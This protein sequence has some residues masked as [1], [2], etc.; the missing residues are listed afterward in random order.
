METPENELE[1]GD[2]SQL[3]LTHK[4][5]LAESLLTG[6]VALAIIQ[7]M[8]GEPGVRTVVKKGKSIAAN[9]SEAEL[10]GV[11]WK[12]DSC[13]GTDDLPFSVVSEE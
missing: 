4:K 11:I 13:V 10:K 6:D 1:K 9:L 3:K 8:Y 2:F 7:Q 5:K 12:C